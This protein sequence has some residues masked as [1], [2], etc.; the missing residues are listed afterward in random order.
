MSP[1]RRTCDFPMAIQVLLKKQVNAFGSSYDYERQV[2]IEEG[3]EP[4]AEGSPIDLP[5]LSGQAQGQEQNQERQSVVL[6]PA[7]DA[8]PTSA[9]DSSHSSLGSVGSAGTAADASRP[10]TV[11]YSTAMSPAPSPS[12]S[13]T[14]ALGPGL[15]SS[16]SSVSSLLASARTSAHAQ[17]FEAAVKSCGDKLCRAGWE[18]WKTDAS[19]G[20][21]FFEQSSTTGTGPLLQLFHHREP[22]TRTEANIGWFVVC[23]SFLRRCMPKAD[24]PCASS[25]EFL[26][27]IDL[28]AQSGLQ[29]HACS[30]PLTIVQSSPVPEEEC[31]RRFVHGLPLEAPP[32][33]EPDP[34]PMP[35]TDRT[36][37]GVLVAACLYVGCAR[38]D[39]LEARRQLVRR[40]AIP[41]MLEPP[42]VEHATTYI[43]DVSDGARKRSGSLNAPSPREVPSSPPTTTSPKA[44]SPRQDQLERRVTSGNNRSGR[45]SGAP[46]GSVLRK[47]SA[48]LGPSSSSA[49]T[50]RASADG[51]RTEG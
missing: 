47:L 16:T 25:D 48:M 22:L 8:S 31:A 30:I 21:Y 1:Q 6:A 5:L 36:S 10:A 35:R 26:R 43:P 11:I 41:I 42:R 39:E 38:V 32:P 44:T 46:S 12:V 4:P 14:L 24:G 7:P 17:H 3:R 28:Y 2:A 15:G 18:C 9:S 40:P 49:G 13:G 27:A 37:R 19:C 20:G 33:G 23:V 29:S 50:G 45:S 34:Q 51:S